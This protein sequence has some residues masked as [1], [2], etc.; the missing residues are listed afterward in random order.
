MRIKFLILMVALTAT[1]PAQAA[2]S[3]NLMQIYQ[4]A[5]SHDPVWMSAQSSNRALQEKLPQGQSQFLPA[6]TFNAGASASKTEF[7]PVGATVFSNNKFYFVLGIALYTK[8]ITFVCLIR[9]VLL[10]P[11]IKPIN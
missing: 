5:L 2:D 11:K 9:S 1:Y 10:S 6:V 3:Q 7:S 8:E 4:Q